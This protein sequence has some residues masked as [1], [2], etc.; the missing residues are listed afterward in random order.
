MNKALSELIELG[1]AKKNIKA[2]GKTWRMHTLDTRDQLSATNS[3]SEYDN[4][5]RVVALKVAIISNAIDAVDGQS[6]G[7]RSER[8]EA[9]GKLPI[10]IINHLYNE[11]E[12][13]LVEQ[14]DKLEK[15]T[16]DNDK[17]EEN[18]KKSSKRENDDDEGE[19]N[20]NEDEDSNEKAI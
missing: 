19:D 4:L 17:D 14:N 5:S 15:L 13:L 8:R 9:F 10:P 6:I 18:K 7:N 20:D 3:T 2:F 12:K 16:E 11:Y 1:S